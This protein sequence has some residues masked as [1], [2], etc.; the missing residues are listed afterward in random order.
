MEL[1]LERD[2]SH[3]ALWDVVLENHG[4]IVRLHSFDNERAATVYLDTVNDV[5]TTRMTLVP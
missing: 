2:N 5:L 4:K 1:R 3:L